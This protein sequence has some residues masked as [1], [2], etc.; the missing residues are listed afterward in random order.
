MLYSLVNSGRFI[1]FFGK[2][3]LIQDGRLKQTVHKSVSLSHPPPSETGGVLNRLVRFCHTH[4]VVVITCTCAHNIT[5]VATGEN[6]KLNVQTLR[7]QPCDFVFVLIEPKWSYL[8]FHLYSRPADLIL[9]CLYFNWS[10]KQSS[11]TLSSVTP[12]P[13]LHSSSLQ[14]PS[15][16]HRYGNTDNSGTLN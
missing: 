15:Y 2:F 7:E 16:F 12:L 11:I 5:C 4:L 6:L 14:R 3:Q 9:P 8:D 1:S 10:L 13:H